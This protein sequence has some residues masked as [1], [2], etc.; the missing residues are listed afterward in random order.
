MS[1]V[2]TISVVPFGC[3]CSRK[4]AI[5]QRNRIR[6]PIDVENYVVCASSTIVRITFKVMF[7]VDACSVLVRGKLEATTRERLPSSERQLFQR[8]GEEGQT[9]KKKKKKKGLTRTRQW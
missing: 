4:R 2:V 7:V 9:C 3:C 5:Q 8:Q 6:D 1:T